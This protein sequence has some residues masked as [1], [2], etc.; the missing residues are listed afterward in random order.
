MRLRRCSSGG[1]R[2]ARF[3]HRALHLAAPVIGRLC[4]PDMRRLDWLA[5]LPSLPAW[6]RRIGPAPTWSPH[7]AATPAQLQTVPGNARDPDA[8]DAAFRAGPLRVFPRLHPEAFAWNL[9]HLWHILVPTWPKVARAQRLAA[10]IQAAPVGEA[11]R[12]S[13]EELTRL[14]RR[15]A[16]RLGLSA[17]GFAPYDP[18]YTLEEFA[19]T[20]DTG[21]VIVCVLEQDF[22]ATQTAPSARA[23]RSAFV[24][25]GELLDR[26]A[27]L[28]EF[29]KRLGV[30]AYAHNPAG[31]TISIY[32]GVQAGLGQMGLNG[33]LLTPQ[34]GSRARLS[35]ITTDAQFD[36]GAPTDFGIHAICDRCQAC[37][38]RCPVGAIPRQRRPYRGVTKAKIKAERCFPVTAQAEGCAVCMKVCPVQRY[39]LQAV[40]SHLLRTGEVLGAGTDELEGYTWPLDGR[41][42]GPQEKPRIDSR[43]VLS[44]PGW[45]FDPSRAAPVPEEAERTLMKGS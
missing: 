8:E 5:H 19:G 37:V 31:E 3:A 18:R 10:R 11:R 7:D 41:R 45:V 27:R 29:L 40:T 21:S 14:A 39:G 35:I 2:R 42:Y 30:D 26:A 17:I 1:R 38:R 23:E 13:P 36:E 12:P 20:H 6:A 15:E 28:A 22:A 32:Y 43:K 25:Y 34:A 4:L 16:E 24:A 44:P 33:Q 9:V